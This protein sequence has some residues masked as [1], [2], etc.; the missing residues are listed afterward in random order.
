MMTI[1][2]TII[3]LP[4]DQLDA[5]ADVCERDQISRAEAIR[6]AVREF[7]R[8][9]ATVNGAAAFGVWRKRRVDGLTYQR[10]LRADW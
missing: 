10:Q 9:R 7:T 5:L 2:R 6:R 1:M 3:D 4:Q 8:T